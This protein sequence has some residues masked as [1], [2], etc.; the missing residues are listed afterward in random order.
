M[1]MEHGPGC[2][3]GKVATKAVA[4]SIVAFNGNCGVFQG[5]T[6][7]RVPTWPA[8]CTVAKPASIKASR[9]GP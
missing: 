9:V 4:A 5:S 3:A 1:L 2:R 6:R 8:I 7:E